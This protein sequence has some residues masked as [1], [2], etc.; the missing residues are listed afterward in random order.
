[1]ASYAKTLFNIITILHENNVF[2]VDSPHMS[3]EER[4]RIVSML[5]ST[6]IILRKVFYLLGVINVWRI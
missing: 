2:K 4:V 6:N 5:E 1:M 3:K